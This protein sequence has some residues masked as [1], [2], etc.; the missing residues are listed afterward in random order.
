MGEEA[1]ALE[2]LR[3]SLERLRSPLERLNEAFY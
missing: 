2:T 1:G 3:S